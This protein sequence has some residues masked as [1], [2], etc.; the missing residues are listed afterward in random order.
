M[1]FP[2]QGDDEIGDLIIPNSLMMIK[3]SPHPTEAKALIDYLLTT[4][5][6]EKTC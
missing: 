1:V 4:E 2:D 3:G 6:E 5:V